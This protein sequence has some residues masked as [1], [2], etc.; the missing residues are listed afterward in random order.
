MTGLLISGKSRVNVTTKRPLTNG[1]GSSEAG[2]FFPAH[3]KGNGYDAVVFRGKASTPVYLYVDGE[4]IEIRDA[5]RLWGKVTGETEKCIKEELEEEKLEIA[6]IWL[7]GE[8]LVRYACIMNMSNHANGR[9]GTGA[10][11]GSKNLKAVVVKKTKPI[12]PY[13]S[14]G[15]KSLTQN[16]KQRFEE[17]PAE[18]TIYFQPVLEK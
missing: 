4:K 18:I 7:A 17:N 1:I 9:N 16:I 14:E 3:L 11:M 6:Q 5:K 12:K 13:D 8:N 10:V 2:G 15:F